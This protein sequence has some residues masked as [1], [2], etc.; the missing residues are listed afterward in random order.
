MLAPRLI[1]CLDTRGGRVVKGVRF[2]DLRDC[3]DPAEL[4]A[5]YEAEGA[6][7]IALLDVA[8]TLEDR[9]CRL[10]TVRAVR[11]ALSLPLCVGGGV[12]SADDARS[13]LDAGADK[14]AVNSQALREPQLVAVLAEKFGSQC[15]VLALDAKVSN[16]RHVVYARAATEATVRDPAAWAAEAASLGAGEILLTSIDRDGTGRGYDLELLGAVRAAVRVPVI[17]SG[18]ASCAAH[19]AAALCCGA[20]AV[21]LASLLHDGAGSVASLKGDLLAAGF[22]VRPVPA[23]S[24][25][26]RLP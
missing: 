10:A 5:R 16:G 17:A 14:V 23:S 19:L 2:A 3:G 24:S 15:T 25:L 18:G 7:E 1:A 6:D 20:D 8:A 22:P 13:L 4:A 12:R 9:G 21:L 11:R 26:D